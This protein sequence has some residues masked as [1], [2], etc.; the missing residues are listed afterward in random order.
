MCSNAFVLEYHL[1]HVTLHWFDSQMRL[2]YYCRASFVLNLDNLSMRAYYFFS[3]YIFRQAY[4]HRL[5][6]YMFMDFLYS[7]AA[8][9]RSPKDLPTASSDAMARAEQR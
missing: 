1:A 6:F 7:L 8:S 4:R 5:V 3:L 2:Y 9:T